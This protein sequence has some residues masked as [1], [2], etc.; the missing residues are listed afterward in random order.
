MIAKII[1]SIA[2]LRDSMEIAKMWFRNVMQNRIP[3]IMANHR[4][5]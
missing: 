3:K 4:N 5:Q 1:S 2:L